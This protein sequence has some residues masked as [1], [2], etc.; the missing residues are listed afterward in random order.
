ML[1]HILSK[2]HINSIVVF[3]YI[4][5]DVIQA[6]I[7]DLNVDLTVEEQLQELDKYQEVVYLPVKL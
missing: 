7:A 1:L 3:R 5:V 2:S 6:S 4:T